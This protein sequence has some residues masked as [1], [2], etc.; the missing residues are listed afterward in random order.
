MTPFDT[1]PEDAAF[2]FFNRKRVVKFVAP[3]RPSPVENSSAALDNAIIVFAIEEPFA[4]RHTDRNCVQRIFGR[5]SS[6]VPSSP[7]SDE[8]KVIRL[9][10]AD[11][12]KVDRLA[13]S[14]SNSSC[15]R[16]REEDGERELPEGRRERS[17][18]TRGIAPSFGNLPPSLS[19]SLSR[20]LF[21]LIFP[22]SLVQMPLVRKHKSSHL[23]GA[24]LD[25][26][27]SRNL[28]G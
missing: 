26:I 12:P 5:C 23:P 17:S 4:T 11:L 28:S 3:A 16:S 21:L 27:A 10:A 13:L 20:S 22:W 1:L 14:K 24:L 18:R 19:L 15:G 25:R 9:L 8:K 2:L 7:R 6:L